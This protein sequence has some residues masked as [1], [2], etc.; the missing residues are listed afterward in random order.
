MNDQEVENCIAVNEL[1]PFTLALLKEN[2]FQNAKELTSVVQ[3][4]NDKVV[5]ELQSYL[6]FP[7]QTWLHTEL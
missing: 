3:K 6:I 7:V 2:T 1:C 5:Q 4:L